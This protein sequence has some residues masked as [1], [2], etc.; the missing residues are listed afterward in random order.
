M[1][2]HREPGRP[3][4]PKAQRRATILSVRLSAEERERVEEA[5]QSL[6]L[7]AAAWARLLMFEE[8]IR[9]PEQRIKRRSWSE[10]IG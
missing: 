7:K 5:A 10:P 2:A 9:P 6:G 8:I 4:L 1:S 3:K